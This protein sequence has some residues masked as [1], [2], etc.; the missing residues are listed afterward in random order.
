M[1]ISMCPTCH[2]EHTWSWEEAFEKFGFEDGDGLV[3]TE[4]VAEALRK[5][6]YTVTVSAWG[7]HNIIIGSIKREGVELIPEDIKLGYDEPRTY[8]PKTIIELL[9]A[10]FPETGEVDL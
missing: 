1:S 10:A 2:H 5:D 8:L 3:V 6:G 4:H 7:C 9:V